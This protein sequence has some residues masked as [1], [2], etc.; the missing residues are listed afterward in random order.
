M[1]DLDK[2]RKAFEATR[3]GE[4]VNVDF[5]VNDYWKTGHYKEK[6]SHY[7]DLEESHTLSMSWFAWVARA[8]LAQAKINELKKEIAYLNNARKDSNGCILN[9]KQKLEK[10]EKLESGEFVLVPKEPTKRMIAVGH[11]YWL[12]KDVYKA[13]IEAVEED[14]AKPTN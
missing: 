14:D 2:E 8:E 12:P 7:E 11:G 9:L 10:L 13:M 3:V 6:T 5:E 1:I 4:F